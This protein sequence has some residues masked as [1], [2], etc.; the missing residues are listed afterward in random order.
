MTFSMTANVSTPL[1]KEDFYQNRL[2]TGWLWFTLLAVQTYN[3]SST[4][5]TQTHQL[6]YPLQERYFPT[7]LRHAEKQRLHLKLTSLT[8]AEFFTSTT[9]I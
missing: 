3:L 4:L 5:A 6:H 7:S 2:P 9:K 8:S 1:N